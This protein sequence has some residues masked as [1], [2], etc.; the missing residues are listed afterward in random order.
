MQYA[1]LDL[2][3]LA[4]SERATILTI[5]ALKFDPYVPLEVETLDSFLTKH[6]DDCFEAV[7]SKQVGRDINFETVQWWVNQEPLAKVMAFPPDRQDWKEVLTIGFP[8]WY[9]HQEPQ[10]C[11]AYPATFDHMILQ[12]A[13]NDLGIKN[14]IH[15]TKI[16]DMRTLVK[17]SAVPC[18]TL[19]PWLVQHNALHDCIRQVLWL[20]AVHTKMGSFAYAGQ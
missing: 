4:T 17:L 19:P 8:A 14:P 1:M 6:K 10:G 18:P 7:L 5:G 12:S 3:T 16:L 11:F 13:Y 9:Y 20:Q 15:Y 2:E